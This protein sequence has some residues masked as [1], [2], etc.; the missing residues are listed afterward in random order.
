MYS[1]LSRQASATS[2]ARSGA[3]ARSSRRRRSSSSPTQYSVP[4]TALPI[5]SPMSFLFCSAQRVRMLLQIRREAALRVAR[6]L[7]AVG[8]GLVLRQVRGA[9]QPIPNRELRREV[10]ARY[11][12]LSRVVP[13]VHLGAVQDALYEANPH[14][15]VRVDVHAPHRVEGGF[16]EGHL[17]RGA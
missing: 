3:G 15:E 17:R 10:L 8:A 11:L 5:R 4:S 13:A 12:E 9:E 1:A 7:Q 2:A 6:L 16:H 14:V